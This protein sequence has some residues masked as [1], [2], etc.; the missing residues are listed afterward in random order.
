MRDSPDPGVENKHVV[1]R[2]AGDQIDT[3][4]VRVKSA[5]CCTKAGRCLT[6]QVGVNAPGTANKTAFLPLNSSSVETSEG[7]VAVM[8]LNL[9][10]G[11]AFPG[12][13]KG[14]A[15]LRSRS[16]GRRRKIVI[17]GL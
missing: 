13:L 17:V 9:A 5:A 1:H 11:S 6:W 4:E 3:L 15:F 14:F 12:H 16:S 8:V 7:P 10:C 2:G